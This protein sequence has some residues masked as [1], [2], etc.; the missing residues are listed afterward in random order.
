MNLIKILS[1][2]LN[3]PLKKTVLEDNDLV[4]IR[5]NG[6]LLLERNGR[7]YAVKSHE[8]PERGEIVGLR[9]IGTKV[10]SLGDFAPYRD[11]LNRPG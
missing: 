3:R 1:S 6:S 4:R 11:I 8:I 2:L 9:Y 10:V 5:E 7:Y